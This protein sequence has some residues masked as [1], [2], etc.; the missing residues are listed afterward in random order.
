MSSF[1]SFFRRKNNLPVADDLPVVQ[2]PDEPVAR[3]WYM[4]AHLLI[5]SAGSGLVAVGLRLLVEWMQFFHTLAYLPLAGAII[6]AVILQWKPAFKPVTKAI[7]IIAGIPLGGEGMAMTCWQHII[8]RLKITPAEKE[9]L[10]LCAVA[11]GLAG[12][13]GT[14]LAAV[15]LTMEVITK[16]ILWRKV[17]FVLI[18]AFVACSI[19]LLCNGMEPFFIIQAVPFPGAAALLIYVLE[20]SGIGLI[21]ALF[22][23]VVRA[24][25]RLPE[26][27]WMPLIA[28]ALIG[29]IAWR[30]PQIL[31]AGYDSMEGMLQGRVTLVLLFALSGTKL[32]AVCLA[33]GAR[34]PGGTLTPSLAMGG[35][36]GILIALGLQAAFPGITL[37]PVT[38]AIAGMT[39]FFAGSSR[40]LLTA[41]FFALESTHEVNVLLPVALAC[42]AACMASAIFLKK[43]TINVRPTQILNR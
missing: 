31:G 43:E 21:A 29:L 25:E 18:A 1:F 30:S 15:V 11:A 33:L 22:I 19:H 2:H 36:F 39:A 20:G 40:A 16:K 12:F 10:R 28:A 14:P 6:A 41:I 17:G 9:L 34:I 3:V 42:T 26:R 37:D 32:V 23:V 13:F 5:V 4:M 8:T 7:Y 35:A 38:A 27:W 24:L